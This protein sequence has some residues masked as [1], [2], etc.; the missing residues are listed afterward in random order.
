MNLSDNGLQFIKNFEGFRANPYLD[1]AGI[2]TIGYGTIL[3]PDGSTV[4]MKDPSISEEQAQ[5][6]L[7]F[8]I[9]HKT[10]SMNAMI[11]I[12]INQNQFDALA[13]FCYNL[14][15]GALHGSTLLRLVNEG[16]FSDASSEFPKW[17]HAG[18]VMVPGLLK[19]RL[20]EQ[21]LFWTPV[22]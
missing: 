11:T 4:T 22:V 9:A 2:A 12:D 14:G 10:S 20:A 7:S 19:R 15:V 17:D 21:T 1:S 18:G 3:Y 13:S 6:Y 8:E 16:N 5:Q